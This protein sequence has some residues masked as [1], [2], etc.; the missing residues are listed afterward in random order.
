MSSISWRA[1]VKPHPAQDTRVESRVCE[2]FLYVFKAA[3]RA[4]RAAAT[5]ACA[6]AGAP[7]A[8]GRTPVGWREDLDDRRAAGHTEQLPSR[9]GFDKGTL[10]AAQ[11][12]LKRACQRPARSPG[13]RTGSRPL[14]NPPLRLRG[15]TAIDLR[16]TF[17]RT[18][19]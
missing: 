19:P 8:A 1:N 6:S 5:A 3:R 15:A 2:N 9:G 7:A 16:P 4:A 11:I 17:D 12:G 10:A 13:K 18:W 14:S